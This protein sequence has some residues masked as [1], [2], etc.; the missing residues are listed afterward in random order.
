M[1]V[2]APA[3]SSPATTDIAHRLEHVTRLFGDVRAV[4]DLSPDLRF[5]LGSAGQLGL[6]DGAWE[7]VVLGVRAEDVRIEAGTAEPTIGSF[8]A[9]VQRL[10]PIGSDTFVELGTGDVTIVARVAT[11]AGLTLGETVQVRLDAGLIHLFDQDSGRR[12]ST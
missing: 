1:T 6:I 10:E 11:D 12:I 7:L 4:D 3:T 9:V 2:A 8:R 5:D